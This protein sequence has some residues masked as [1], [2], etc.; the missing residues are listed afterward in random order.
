MAARDAIAAA[1]SQAAAGSLEAHAHGQD[2]RAGQNV[3]EPEPVLKE[4]LVWI[5]QVV[6]KFAG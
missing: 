5:G 4:E 1:D 2:G 3:S 6:G